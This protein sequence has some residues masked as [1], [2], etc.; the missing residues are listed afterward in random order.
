MG[1]FPSGTFTLNTSAN[2]NVANGEIANCT[3]SGTGKLIVTNGINAGGNSGNIF[4][5]NN[6]GAIALF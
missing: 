1:S 5:N 3:L 4:W 2:L 6:A